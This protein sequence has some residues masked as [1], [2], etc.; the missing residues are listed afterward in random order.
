M[1]GIRGVHRGLGSGSLGE[2][3]TAG[4]SGISA[5]PSSVMAERNAITLRIESLAERALPV[6]FNNCGSTY[7]EVTNSVSGRSVARS[8]DLWR[9]FIS[10]ALQNSSLAEELTSSIKNLLGITRVK[11][12]LPKEFIAVDGWIDAF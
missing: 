5:I 1:E 10:V 12:I 6:F 2:A 11:M 4:Y 7:Q 3:A 8:F 9:F